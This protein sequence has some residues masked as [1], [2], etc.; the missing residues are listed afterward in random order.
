[1][2]NSRRREVAVVSG[3]G[4]VVVIEVLHPVRGEHCRLKDVVRG[5]GRTVNGKKGLLPP[6]HG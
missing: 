4:G 1:M 3:A 5:K 2:R 6:V